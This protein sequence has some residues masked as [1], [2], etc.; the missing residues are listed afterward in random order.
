M[1]AV[2]EDEMQKRDAKGRFVKIE[3]KGYKGFDC[4]M[5]CRGKKYRPNKVH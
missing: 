5:I 2:R 4:G 1:A 3:E